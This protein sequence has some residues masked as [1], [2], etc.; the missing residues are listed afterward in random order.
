MDFVESAVTSKFQLTLPRAVRDRLGIRENDRV[1]FLMENMNVR[2][3]KKPE[4]IL[5]AMSEL[6]EGK[7]F[8]NIRDEFRKD[9]KSW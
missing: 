5:K 8:L 2:V 1:V 3:I 4:N 7:R 6:S 9:R